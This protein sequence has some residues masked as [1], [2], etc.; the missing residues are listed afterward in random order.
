MKK[1]DIRGLSLQV[2][3]TQDLLLIVL[4][5]IFHEIKGVWFETEVVSMKAGRR[6]AS[7]E[8]RHRL[9]TLQS[10]TYLVR[11]EV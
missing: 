10:K 7:L 5:Q 2:A 1:F 9:K 6:R 3:L 8:F 11:C 4:P